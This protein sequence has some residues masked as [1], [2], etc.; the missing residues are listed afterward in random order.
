MKKLRQ[1]FGIL[2][3]AFVAT[4]QLGAQSYPFNPGY[5][6]KDGYWRSTKP[7]F[8][9][10]HEG[11]SWSI[12]VKRYERNLSTSFSDGSTHSTHYLVE[13]QPD[14]SYLYTTTHSPEI[15]PPYDAHEPF[16]YTPAR[17]L[18]TCAASGPDGGSAT[19]TDTVSTT[20]E[21]ENMVFRKATNNTNASR[22][23]FSVTIDFYITKNDPDCLTQATLPY[24]TV[25][26]VDAPYVKEGKA[27]VA[28]PSGVDYYIT[29]VVVGKTND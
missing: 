22:D 25:I 1:W 29:S 15:G 20:Y 19:T 5:H 6:T 28:A 9:A 7:P 24:D 8:G 10:D 17:Y 2:V 16:N 27:S 26:T 4:L 21:V 12:Y 18:Y 23:P 3:V 13:L 14:G 11:N